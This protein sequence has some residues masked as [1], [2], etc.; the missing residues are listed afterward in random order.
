LKRKLE[1]ISHLF[2]VSNVIN[3][4][5]VVN[6][7]LSSL[8]RGV[9]LKCLA[10]PSSIS[11]LNHVTAV[12]LSALSVISRERCKA[13]A[14]G[15]WGWYEGAVRG[16]VY[17]VFCSTLMRLSARLVVSLAKSWRSVQLTFRT[18]EVRKRLQKVLALRR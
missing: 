13:R 9:S 16:G 4:S 15:E 1:N 17:P 3:F 6:L 18:A 8:S 2:Y 5:Y 10:W 12:Q 7:L 14:Y 11:G